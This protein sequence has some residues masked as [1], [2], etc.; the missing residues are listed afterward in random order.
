M[1]LGEALEGHRATSTVDGILGIRFT[2][3][4]ISSYYFD[5]ICSGNVCF[6]CLY[7]PIENDSACIRTY[8]MRAMCLNRSLGVWLFA[9]HKTGL[10]LLG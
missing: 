7:T 4:T 8:K 10:R 9:Q 5:Q 1:Y 2:A 6:A 3:Y